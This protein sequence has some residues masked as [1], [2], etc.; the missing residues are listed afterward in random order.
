MSKINNLWKKFHRIEAEME[1]MQKQTTA[2]NAKTGELL[3][4]YEKIQKAEANLASWETNT[5]I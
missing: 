3:E 2:Y 1:Q 4:V 5:D